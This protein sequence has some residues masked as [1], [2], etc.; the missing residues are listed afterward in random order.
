MVERTVIQGP[1]SSKAT[2]WVLWVKPD[3]TS[4]ITVVPSDL[5]V[6]RIGLLQLPRL[7]QTHPLIAGKELVIVWPI[8][9]CLDIADVVI[10][11]ALATASL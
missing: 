5:G 3:P 8:R 6:L 1:E 11:H 4:A 7:L 9:S 2:P 10:V